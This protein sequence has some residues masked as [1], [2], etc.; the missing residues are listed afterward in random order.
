VF[1]AFFFHRHLLQFRV[2]RPSRS[3][4]LETE[5]MQFGISGSTKEL[6]HVLRFGLS[7]DEASVDSPKHFDIFL[8]IFYSKCL[9]QRGRKK[10]KEKLFFLCIE[11]PTIW[12]GS[13]D[14]IYFF[15]SSMNLRRKKGNFRVQLARRRAHM[16]NMNFYYS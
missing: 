7:G 15:V 8:T 13:C 4:L 11:E 14:T 9:P 16:F 12:L 5:V 1:R 2:D 10:K 3:A 6:N